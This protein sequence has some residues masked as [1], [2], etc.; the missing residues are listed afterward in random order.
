LNHLTVPWGILKPAFLFLGFITLEM[1]P[2]VER[3]L[4]NCHKTQLLLRPHY[5]KTRGQDTP[6]CSNEED[7][8]YA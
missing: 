8:G 5:S 7:R 3:A 1:P 2:P 4:H 6:F